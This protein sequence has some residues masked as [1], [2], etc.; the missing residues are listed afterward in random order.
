MSYASRFNRLPM[1]VKLG[2]ALGVTVVVVKVWEK[3]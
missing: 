3:V 1:L 2:I